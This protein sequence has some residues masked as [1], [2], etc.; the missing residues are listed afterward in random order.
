L[1]I[2]DMPISVRREIVRNHKDLFADLALAIADPDEGLRG[3]VLAATHVKIWHSVDAAKPVSTR[4]LVGKIIRSWPADKRKARVEPFRAEV[5]ERVGK[6]GA[7]RDE[8]F[9]SM[10]RLIP[11]WL[12]L[13]PALPPSE[14]LLA[15]PGGSRGHYL[16]AGQEAFFRYGRVPVSVQEMLPCIG[17]LQEAVHIAMREKLM[18]GMVPYPAR[19]LLE[20]KPELQEHLLRMLTQP[21]NLELRGTEA[22]YLTS[23]TRPWTAHTLPV[24]GLLA[25]CGYD[26]GPPDSEG[27]R[28]WFREYEHCNDTES[29]L[30]IRL[31]SSVP[32]VPS[33]LLTDAVLG[34]P[35]CRS[36]RTLLAERALTGGHLAPEAV[37]PWW[38]EPLGDGSGLLAH[39]AADAG[40]NPGLEY[41]DL[42]KRG[43]G[44][45]LSCMASRT[46]DPYLPEPDDLDH[47]SF[48]DWAALLG[49]LGNS[50]F[51][52]ERVREWLGRVLA[53]AGA[54]PRED[55]RKLLEHLRD[56][57]WDL[58]SS[59]PKAA[60]PMAVLMALADGPLWADPFPVG[61]SGTLPLSVHLF[62]TA[63]RLSWQK[64]PIM[65]AQWT[66][67]ME[68]VLPDVPEKALR[69]MMG[70]DYVQTGLLR[71]IPCHLSGIEDHRPAIEKTADYYGRMRLQAAAA[72]GLGLNRPAE[73][74]DADFEQ[75][76]MIL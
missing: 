76:L 52:P 75:D 67:L 66:H 39:K 12:S 74:G 58:S 19:L 17:M 3:H 31:R 10:A 25:Q 7:I 16:C 62:R 9:G 2:D 29:L 34:R 32:G 73:A 1:F 4:D 26:F 55:R 21:E 23:G 65:E 11:C 5:A 24:C 50:A 45:V 30:G 64:C 41:W 60:H 68:R 61:S 6:E 54:L 63:A 69:E 72:R 57:T 40:A 51:D 53:A 15:L 48:S 35:C 46:T 43:G 27:G 18:V 44:T 22:L 38:R 37:R 59:K 56:Y 49:V 70:M 20:R 13:L 42:R 71:Q 8:L 33:H 36:G 28:W 14:T 47:V